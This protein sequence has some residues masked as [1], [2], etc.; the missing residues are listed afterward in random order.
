MSIYKKT[1]FLLFPPSWEG[2][3]GKMFIKIKR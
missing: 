2:E 1:L 3:M